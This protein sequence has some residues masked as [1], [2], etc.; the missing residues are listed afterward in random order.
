MDWRLV[1]SVTKERRLTR[2]EKWSP[3][4]K[5]MWIKSYHEAPDSAKFIPDII[6]LVHYCST[7]WLQQMRCNGAGIPFQKVSKKSIL[8]MKG[9]VEAYF[10]AQPILNTS[11][12]YI[13]KT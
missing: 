6:A 1:M 7:S 11:Q 8:Y 2:L 3:E 5:A 10:S 12:T 4:E 9:D 13:K